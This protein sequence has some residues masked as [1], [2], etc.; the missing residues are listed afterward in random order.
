[1]QEFVQKTEIAGLFLIE[2]PT[3]RDDR[4]FF[5]EVVRLRELNEALRATCPDLIEEFRPIQWNHSCSL[6]RVIRGLHAE[7]W[8]KLVYPM[9]GEMF[10]AIVDIRPHS[11]TF[12]KVETFVF[13]ESEP[14]A[15]FLV[16]G[17]ANSICV[18]GDTPVHY[19]YLVDREYDG[20]DTRAIAWDDP[21]LAIR[22]PVSDP[23]ISE[24]DRKNPRLRD[25]FPDRFPRD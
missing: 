2:R 11:P 21:D 22:W 18:I 5:R 23:I 7:N 15:M 4:G 20:T 6:P 13:R 14:R 3:H 16:R 1:M 10:A 9:T 19:G 17:L 25:L 12:G 8:N 24:R